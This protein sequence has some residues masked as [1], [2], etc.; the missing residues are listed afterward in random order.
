MNT[1]VPKTD[2]E[3]QQA[4]R[5]PEVQKI[6]SDPAMHVILEQMKND[7]TALRDHLK[8]PVIA[9]KIQTLI[10]AGVIQTR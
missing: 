1:N 7:P 2:E 4:M 9:Q 8:N 6:L 5:N 3:R 10:S